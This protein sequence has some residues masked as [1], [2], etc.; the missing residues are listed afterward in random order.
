MK[1]VRRLE[2]IKTNA[3]YNPAMKNSQSLINAFRNAFNGLFHF[4]RNERNAK[5]QSGIG[6]LVVVTACL[7][8]VSFFEWLILLLCIGWVL[9]LEMLNSALEKLCDLV[10]PSYHP[11]IKT[12]KDV[13]AAAVL[14][15]SIIS[16]LIGGV[17]FLPRILKML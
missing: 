8:N 14:W 15:T 12:V 5:I 10:N 17:I 4:F 2:N 6:I 3:Y 7:L 11:V 9:S 16:A 1:E 13:S